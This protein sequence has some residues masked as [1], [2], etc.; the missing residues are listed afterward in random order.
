MARSYHCRVDQFSYDK[1]SPLHNRC[2]IKTSWVAA[3]IVSNEQ[4]NNYERHYLRFKQ[5]CPTV[6][7]SNCSALLAPGFCHINGSSVWRWNSKYSYNDCNSECLRSAVSRLV[8]GDSEEDIYW[9]ITSREIQYILLHHYHYSTKSLISFVQL[10]HCIMRVSLFRPPVLS[11]QFTL[12]NNSK[13]CTWSCGSVDE[14][15]LPRLLLLL[16]NE[17]ESCSVS[18]EDESESVRWCRGPATSRLTTDWTVFA[19]A[20]RLE[21]GP[22][23][24]YGRKKKISG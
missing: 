22:K 7:T 3:A 10:S 15:V 8:D 5:I 17:D 24:E 14:L 23:S 9:A 11:L 1:K 18:E 21:A 16:F 6:R 20:I 12:Q 4:N 13:E 2:T 19:N